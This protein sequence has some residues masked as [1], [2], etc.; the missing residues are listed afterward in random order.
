M[1]WCEVLAIAFSCFLA[2]YLSCYYQNM[3]GDED[4]RSSGN[5]DEQGNDKE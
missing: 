2:G 5:D 4:E 3:K 1:N